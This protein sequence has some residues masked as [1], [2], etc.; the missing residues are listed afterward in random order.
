M[1]FKGSKVNW[2]PY[3]ITHTSLSPAKGGAG[4]DH[5]PAGVWLVVSEEEEKQQ[6]QENGKLKLLIAKEVRREA[7]SAGGMEDWLV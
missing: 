1:R 7:G 3:Q 4:L 5:E 2:H 6:D